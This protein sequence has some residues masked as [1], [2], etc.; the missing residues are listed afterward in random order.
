MTR[1]EYLAT[2]WEAA[3]Q[4]SD[5][6]FVL[7]VLYALR[8]EDAARQIRAAL[9]APERSRAALMKAMGPHISEP[10]ANDP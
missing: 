8:D 2:L 3:E 6:A 7:V 5:T 10:P 9:N 4:I 1:D